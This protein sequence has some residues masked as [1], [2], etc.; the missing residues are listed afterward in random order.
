MTENQ[1]YDVGIIFGCFI[2]LHSGHEKLIRHSRNHHE[3]TIVAVCGRDGDRGQ[4]FIPFRD[5]IKLIRE[6]FKNARDVIVVCVDDD[7][8]GMD[9]TFSLHNW[10]IWCRELLNNA[11][12]SGKE[13][14]TWYM[15]EPSYAEK[16]KQLYPNHK[17]I[18]ADRN[19]NPISGTKIRGNLQ[20]YRSDVNA[21]FQ[22]YLKS[23]EIQMK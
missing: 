15:G 23:S 19:E 8:I 14:I 5:R 3:H 6:I 13:E 4:D 11:G 17:I 21:R 12:L 20:K 10:D 2:P 1:K 22:E 9:G 7:K 16:I 18:V